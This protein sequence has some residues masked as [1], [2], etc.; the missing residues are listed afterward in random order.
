MKPDYSISRTVLLATLVA[1][2][3]AGMSAQSTGTG[4]GPSSTP[5]AQPAPGTAPVAGDS[6]AP[7]TPPTVSKQPSDQQPPSSTPPGDGKSDPTSKKKPAPGTEPVSGD[8]R[9]RALTRKRLFPSAA[10]SS[11]LSRAALKMSMR[12]EIATSVRVAWATG[13]PPTPKSRWAKP[14]RMRL[15]RARS[16]S[17]IRL[18]PST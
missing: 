7:S 16:S 13:T 2:L 12:S 5:S 9:Q 1:G 18:S 4:S 11:R 3:A 14:M 10:N 17:P 8:V 6:Q 15:K